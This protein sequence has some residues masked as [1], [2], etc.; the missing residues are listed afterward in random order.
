MVITARP[1]ISKVSYGLCSAIMLY[2]ISLFSD[3]QNLIENIKRSV[4]ITHRYK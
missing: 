3:S 2:F 4:M 1:I